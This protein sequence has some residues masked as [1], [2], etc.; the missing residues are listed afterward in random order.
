[1][2]GAELKE[3]WDRSILC[4]REFLTEEEWTGC[5]GTQLPVIAELEK[6]KQEDPNLNLKHPVSSKTSMRQGVRMRKDTETWGPV[7]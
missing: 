2:S 5:D 6:E 1:M 3:S 7:F 4:A